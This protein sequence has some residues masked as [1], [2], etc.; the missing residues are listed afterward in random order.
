AVP[1]AICPTEVYRRGAYFQ[2][3][4]VNDLLRQMLVT[5][6][7]TDQLMCNWE[8]Y[9]YVG[10][11]CF[12]DRCQAE[13][14]QFSKLPA[15]D[16]AATWPKTV[17]EKHG[18]LLRRF[19]R[20]QHAQFMTTVEETVQALGQEAGRE[21]QFIPELH[22][23]NLTSGWEKLGDSAE[24]AAVDYL[25]K[26]PALNAWGP[27]NW[28]VFGRGPYEYVRG[29]HLNCHATALQVQEFLRSRLP[30]DKQPALYAFP[31]GTYEGA[32]EPEAI[33]FELLTYFLDGYRGAL[34][35]LYPGGYDARHWRAL[36]EANAQ[37]ARFE[38]FVMQGR[39]QSRH[40]VAPATP[41]PPPDP[42]FLQSGC[43]SA[44]DLERWQHAPLLQ[45]WEF[46][47]D[48]RRLF[49]V[50]NFWERGDC[51]FKL[52]VTASPG[53][54][55]LREPLTGRTYGPAG[56]GAALS[57]GHLSQGVLL[58]VGAL[59]YAFFV[60]E[61]YR[62]DGKYGTAIRPQEMQAALQERL[63]AIRQAAAQ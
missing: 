63:P 36:G 45:S 27:Y 59:R 33:G 22:Y 56:G 23:V 52:T 51:F 58:H 30:A 62:A 34:V 24:F 10:K 46:E 28:F 20:W 29:L 18:D 25:D 55:V 15:A 47:R 31:Y 44:T 40:Q 21:M 32:T 50:G 42:R 8:P 9:M 7:R 53:K 17:A 57:A 11:G 6:R 2:S 48:G 41:L 43:M 49:A 12:C 37:I 60:L 54:Y 61:A 3:A 4:I 1:G 13:F 16:V 35:Y 19:R 5:N 26:L 38:S 14:A 39:R